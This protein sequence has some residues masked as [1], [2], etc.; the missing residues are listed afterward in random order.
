MTWK[1]V[2]MKTQDVDVAEK[3]SPPESDN[4][5]YG[6]RIC[7]T[8]PELARLGFAP[9]DLPDVGDTLHFTA[10]A[11]VTSFSQNDTETGSNC[12]VELQITQMSAED[13]SQEFPDDEAN[14]PV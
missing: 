1:F 3:F 14:E 12:R 10:M 2:D 5:P 4:Y 8:G 9:D 6:L 7:L 11:V 13:E